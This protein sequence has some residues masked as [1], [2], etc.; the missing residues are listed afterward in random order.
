MAIENNRPIFLESINDLKA[1]IGKGI[2]ELP[3][4]S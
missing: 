4:T 2:E 1:S 3:Y